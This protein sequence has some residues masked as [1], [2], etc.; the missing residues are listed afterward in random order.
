MSKNSQIL[1]L[2]YSKFKGKISF[3]YFLF[4]VRS[5]YTTIALQSRYM[6]YFRPQV[7]AASP[8]FKLKLI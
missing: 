1:I 8:H 3:V 6:V 5:Y 2:R 7:T 4:E